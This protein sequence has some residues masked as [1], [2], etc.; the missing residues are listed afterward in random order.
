ML[1]DP[2]HLGLSGLVQRFHETGLGAV[3]ESR[4]GHGPNKA[5]TPEQL[6]RGLGGARLQRLSEATGLEVDALGRQLV[7]ALPKL[8][9]KLTPNGTVPTGRIPEH[10]GSLI[11][12]KFY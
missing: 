2:R 10:P 6:G 9:D 7:G 11:K 5:I 12:G 8:I 4:I 1:N 3:I